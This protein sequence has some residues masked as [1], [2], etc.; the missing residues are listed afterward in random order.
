VQ[1]CICAWWF[2][3]G[4]HTGGPS[5]PSL[6]PAAACSQYEQAK[7]AISEEN[8]PHKTKMDV[9]YDGTFKQR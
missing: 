9:A 7:D 4:G 1:V 5:C 3:H 2:P 6:C 8:E